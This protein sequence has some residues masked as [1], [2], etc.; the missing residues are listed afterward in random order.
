MLIRNV[1]HTFFA[2]ATYSWNEDS[3]Y[4][5]IQSKDGSQ[6]EDTSDDD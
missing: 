5:S 2:A 4:L 1:K 6:K 3:P